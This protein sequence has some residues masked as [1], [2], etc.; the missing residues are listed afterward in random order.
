V[1]RNVARS[2]E[3]KRADGLYNKPGGGNVW[4]ARGGAERWAGGQSEQ[5]LGG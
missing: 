3:R 2:G 4:Y 1:R 5:Q